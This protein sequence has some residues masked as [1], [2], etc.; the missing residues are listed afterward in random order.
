[1][2]FVSSCLVGINCKYSGGNNYNQKVFDLVKEGKAIPIC[3]EQLGGLQTPRNPAEIKIIDGKKHVIDDKNKD[4]TENFEKGAK[5]VLELAKKLNIEK[6][7]LQARSPSCGVGKI[8]SGNFDGKLIQGNGIL[9]ELFIENGIEV[10]NSEDYLRKEGEKMKIRNANINDLNRIT[11]IEKIC[12]PDSEAASKKSFEGRLTDYPNHFWVLE[13]DNEIVSFINGLVTDKEHLE[14]EMYSNS[15]IHNENGAW[16]MIFGVDTIPEYRGRGCAGLLIKKMIENAKAENRKG[17]VLT[18]KDHLVK[19]Y[20]KFG[21][22]DEGISE[23]NHG[24]VTWH[25]MRLRF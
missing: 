2:I 1:M 17:L 21:F 24:G 5:E 3:P 11:E 6:A 7:I 13:D 19:Y 23:S 18:C 16:Q 8:Y 20:S 25:E 10:I 4:V 9:A 14:D 15:S 12:F 22:I